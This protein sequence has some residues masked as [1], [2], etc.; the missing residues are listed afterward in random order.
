MSYALATDAAMSRWGCAP[1]RSILAIEC[2]TPEELAFA[3]AKLRAR[4]DM[5]RVRSDESL[6]RQR[7]GQH[8]A[9]YRRDTHPNWFPK[10]TADE[11]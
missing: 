10:E 1:R 7:D 2:A 8:I 11:V 9:V 5:R 6:P 4:P 3:L